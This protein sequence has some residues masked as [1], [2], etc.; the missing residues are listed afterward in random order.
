MR[1]GLRSNPMGVDATDRLADESLVEA[2]VLE[3][4]KHHIAGA[5]AIH[6]ITRNDQGAFACD[7]G[8]RGR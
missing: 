7:V 6:G 4:S 2:D 1:A 3:L 5:T 8:R